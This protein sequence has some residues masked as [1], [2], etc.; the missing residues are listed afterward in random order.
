MRDLSEIFKPRLQLPVNGK[1]YDVWDP[2]AELGARLPEVIATQQGVV[3]LCETALEVLGPALEE[4]IEDGL[5]WTEI[6][7]C[8]RTAMV[9]FGHS[10]QLANAYWHTATLV[11]ALPAQVVEHLSRRTLPSVS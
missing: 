2:P 5:R 9:F 7:H 4:M 10:P 11:G 6:Q 1:I 3:E 8:G